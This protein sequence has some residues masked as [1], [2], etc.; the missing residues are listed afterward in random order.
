MILAPSR[1]DPEH[2]CDYNGEKEP[3]VYQVIDSNGDLVAG[4]MAQHDDH[5]G[6]QPIGYDGDRESE[7]DENES[8]L[9]RTVHEI[10]E[11]RPGHQGCNQ[12]S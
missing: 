10:R 1:A 8:A 2:A 5:V 12:I 6:T 3:A 7:R 9:G 4:K 11:K